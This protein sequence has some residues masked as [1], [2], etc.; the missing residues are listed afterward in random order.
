MGDTIYA[1]PQ[2]CRALRA[3]A[4]PLRSLALTVLGFKV[5][6]TPYMPQLPTHTERLAENLFSMFRRTP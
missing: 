1:S 4:Y 2:E 5:I 3:A 6:E